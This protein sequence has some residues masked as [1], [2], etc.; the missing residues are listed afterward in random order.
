MSEASPHKEN[1]A[2][3]SGFPS[4][5]RFGE[6]TS[7][8][9]HFGKLASNKGP[10]NILRMTHDS[11]YQPDQR[12]KAPLPRKPQLCH[13]CVNVT[14]PSPRQSRGFLGCGNAS[15]RSAPVEMSFRVANLHNRRSYHAERHGTT[16][17]RRYSEVGVVISAAFP[18]LHW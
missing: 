18:L 13:E 16:T 6:V 5:I 10:S 17:R 14:T 15:G 9:N 1:D 11:T 8:G 12:V 7:P 3:C 4:E 2:A